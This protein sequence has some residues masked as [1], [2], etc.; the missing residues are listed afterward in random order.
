MSARTR[1]ARP[2]SG[3][4]S[5]GVELIPHKDSGETTST[6]PW[7]AHAVYFRDPAGNIVEVIARHD[8]PTGKSG[9]F[10]IHDDLLWLSE[11]GLVVDSAAGT[12]IDLERRLGLPA[13][14][15]VDDGFA[16][17]G[18]EEGLL[19][20]VE[21]GRP[22]MPDEREPARAWPARVLVDAACVKTG[23]GRYGIGGAGGIGYELVAVEVD[24]GSEG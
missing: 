12:M 24:E 6:S 5:R 9:P 10:D 13:Y 16:P 17:I 22:W 21:T 23:P 8:L 18:D 2:A 11:I 4:S 7:N 3:S 20:V 1:S 19:I 14:I 15:G